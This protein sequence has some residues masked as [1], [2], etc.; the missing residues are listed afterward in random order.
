MQLLRAWQFVNLSRS[1]RGGLYNIAHLRRGI[2]TLGRYFV[3]AARVAG[4]SSI[5]RYRPVSDTKWPIVILAGPSLSATKP[6]C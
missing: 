3:K 6:P 4:Q 2:R 5:G 1:S